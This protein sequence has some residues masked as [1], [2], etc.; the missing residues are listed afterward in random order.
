MFPSINTVNGAL[1]GE[2]NFGMD[3]FNTLDIFF[4]LTFFFQINLITNEKKET[5][6]QYKETKKYDP[7]AHTIR[8]IVM[9]ILHYKNTI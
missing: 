4:V 9:N 8:C 3:V 7:F 6:S 1:R 2:D 5:I